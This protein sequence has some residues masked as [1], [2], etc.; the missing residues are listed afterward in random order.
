MIEFVIFSSI[1]E[2][3]S[4]VRFIVAECGML[5]NVPSYETFAICVG[6]ISKSCSGYSKNECS[7]FPNFWNVGRTNSVPIHA[8]NS[9]FQTGYGVFSF[10]SYEQT[11]K[12][13]IAKIAPKTD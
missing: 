12:M 13:I 4:D 9:L 8:M 2:V 5:I 10:G 3:V 7:T 6:K 11:T 1:S